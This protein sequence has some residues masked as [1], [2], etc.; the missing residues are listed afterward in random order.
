VGFLMPTLAY[1]DPA[2]KVKADPDLALV[3]DPGFWFWK[4]FTAKKES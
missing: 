2:F 1:P 4:K 3:P